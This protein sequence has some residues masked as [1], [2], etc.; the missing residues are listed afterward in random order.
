M[1][2]GKIRLMCRHH[3]VR[4]TKV[5]GSL[6]GKRKCVRP[7]HRGNDNIKVNLK[8]MRIRMC[9]GLSGPR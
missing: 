6:L 7:S 5:R 3:A 8:L 2:N 1:L 4:R 9:F